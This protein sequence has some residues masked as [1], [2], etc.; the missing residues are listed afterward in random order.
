MATTDRIAGADTKAERPAGSVLLAAG[1]I[2]AAIGASSCCVV[3]LV[4]FALGISGAWIGNLTA[5]APYQPFFVA[6]ALAFL[7]FGF[8][9]VYRCKPA[10]CAPG[11]ACARPMPNRAVKVALWSAAV[12]V[13][14]AIAFPYAAPLLLGT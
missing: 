13:A 6:A 4:F 11:H 3:P 7:G 5:L 14:L 8:F 1:G 2:L 9:R 10:A 12:L